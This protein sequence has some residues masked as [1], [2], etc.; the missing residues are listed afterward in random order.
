MLAF[1]GRLIERKEGVMP[2]DVKVKTVPATH[3]AAIRRHTSAA[4]IGPDIQE[5]FG[6]IGQT[7][8]TAGVPIIGPPYL[9]MFDVI[10]DETDGDVE[11][12]FPVAS[13]FEGAGDVR[14][15]DV[16]EMTVAWTL[17]Q[18]PYDEIG[19]AYHTVSGWIQEHGHE[20]AGPPRE[21]YLTDPSETTDPAEYETEVQFPIR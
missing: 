17:H 12:A 6:A 16:P 10:D 14:S 5:A 11:L 8:G 21:I 15:V 9:V 18:G 2:Y 4:T 13:A 1:I 3:V 7:I 20:V 19:P